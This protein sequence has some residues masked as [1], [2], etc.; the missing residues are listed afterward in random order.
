MRFLLNSFIIYCDTD[1]GVAHADQ[2]ERTVAVGGQ[3]QVR[4]HQHTQPKGHHSLTRFV[5]GRLR[6]GIIGKPP[7]D[8]RQKR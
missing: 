2:K 7:A 6:G 4:E 3:G 8:H 1:T 5:F